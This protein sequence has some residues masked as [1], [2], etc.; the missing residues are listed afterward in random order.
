MA[1]LSHQYIMSVNDEHAYQVPSKLLQQYRFSCQTA[2]IFATPYLRFRMVSPVSTQPAQLLSWHQTRGHG[3]A[4][5]HY[6]CDCEEDSMKYHFRLMEV[7][8]VKAG[9]G[10]KGDRKTMGLP[11]ALVV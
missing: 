1:Y 2:Y 6:R 4:F 3:A 11:T 5:C 7:W 10:R 9:K 8:E